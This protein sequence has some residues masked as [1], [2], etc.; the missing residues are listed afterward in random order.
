M[1]VL[2]LHRDVI[3]FVSQV[4]QTTSTAVRADEEGVLI[5]SPVLPGE[6]AA[7]P[8]VVEQAGFAV[9]GLLATHGDWDHMLGRLAFPEASFGCAETTAERLGRR[10]GEPQR[11]LRRFDEEHYLNRKRP[12]QLGEVQRLPVPGRL[13][14]GRSGELE[15]HPATGHSPDG[16]AVLVP[17]ANVLIAG[18]YVSPV[19]I[20]MLH[21]EESSL[22]DYQDTLRRLRGLIERVETVIPGHGEPLSAAQARA[23]IAQ[24]EAY[25]E[26]L[27][28]GGGAPELPPGRRTP[29]QRRIHAENI[30]RLND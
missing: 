4:W 7:M 17:W 18:D 14:L 20:P 8:G 3:V 13:A 25:L 10:P 16:M 27:A 28:G 1:R 29:E 19:E 5:D 24:D 11:E 22:V 2:A 9:S 23:L 6:L 21:D 15:L 30:A 12:L 26:A